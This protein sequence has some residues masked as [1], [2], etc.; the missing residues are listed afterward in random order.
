[1]I[2]GLSDARHAGQALADVLTMQEVFGKLAGRRLVY[3]GD[4][5]N[6]A[7]SLAIIT[8]Q[9][10][11]P[12]TVCA[13]EGYQLS[14][15]FLAMLKK[16][17]PTSDLTCESD[18]RTAVADASVI[19]TDV[20][21]SMGQESEAEERRQAFAP[22]SMDGALRASAPADCRFMHCLPARR[23]IEVTDDV[24]DGPQSIVF[25]QAENR[26]HLAKGLLVWLIDRSSR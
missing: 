14:S 12:M 15:D 21:T 10:Q 16:R 25:Q 7:M 11:L 23:G 3:V 20:W 22:Y 5:N 13:P 9:L 6:V 17:L 19:Y 8:A 1:M 18:P 4:G 26:M 24:V 2:N